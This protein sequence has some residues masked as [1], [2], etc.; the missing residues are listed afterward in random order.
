MSTWP[1][2][3]VLTED[4]DLDDDKYN[5]EKDALVERLKKRDA[6]KQQQEQGIMG[7]STTV[8]YAAIS[9]QPTK[10]HH[11]NDLQG[12]FPQLFGLPPT[13]SSS[14]QKDKSKALQLP[15]AIHDRAMNHKKEDQRRT[16]TGN[17]ANTKKLDAANDKVT[18][19]MAND[20]KTNKTIDG[21]LTAHTA[22]FVLPLDTMIIVHTDMKMA[23]KTRYS[24]IH[25]TIIPAMPAVTLIGG[26]LPAAYPKQFNP[27]N[28][29]SLAEGQPIKIQQEHGK[30]S[31]K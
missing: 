12:W 24:T 26:N 23:T 30:D 1:L 5:I 25:K 10:T 13:H 21:M 4:E 27:E 19:V 6:K 7:P 17:I 29:L 3:A 11:D 9:P 14:K 2:A 18:S 31:E 22:S 16:E 28:N 15:N 20:N 8:E